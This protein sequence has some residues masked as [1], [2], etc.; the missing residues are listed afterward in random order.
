MHTFKDRAKVSVAARSDRAAVADSPG[1]LSLAERLERVSAA[2]GRSPA[3][4][5]TRQDALSP[6]D[7]ARPF[8]PAL[9]LRFLQLFAPG[10]HAP[11][12]LVDVIA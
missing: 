8:V 6:W 7:C 12:M 3:P 5:A 10:V 4:P 2:T 11:G 9:A 1:H